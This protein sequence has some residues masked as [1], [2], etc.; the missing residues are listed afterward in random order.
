MNNKFHINDLVYFVKNEEVHCGD[1]VTSE[2]CAMIEAWIQLGIVIESL[3][4][5][6]N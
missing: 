5:R 6:K 1:P 2:P 3:F 4:F